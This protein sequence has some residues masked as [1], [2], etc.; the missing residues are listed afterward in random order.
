M[1]TLS[2]LGI[3]SGLDTAAMLEQMRAAEQTR[4]NPYTTLKSSYENKISAWGKISSALSSLQTSVKKLSGEAFNTL[5][6]SDNKAFKATATSEAAADSHSVTVK[7]LAVSHKLRTEGYTSSEENLGDKTGGTRTITITQANGKEITV[8]LADDETS[9]DQIAKAINKQDGGV[10]A[11]VQRSDD[12]YQLVL[13]SRTAGTEGQMSVQVT[14]DDALGDILNTSEGG[15]RP[16]PDDENKTIAENDRM[17]SVAEAQDAQLIVDGIS[18]TRSSNSITDI[19]AGVTLNLTGV[20]EEGKAEQLTLN[21]DTSAIK[22]TLQEFVKQYNALLS[23]TSSASKFVPSDTSGLADDDVAKPSSENGALM[24]D[25]TLRGLVG[26]LRSVVNGV[27]GDKDVNVSALSSLGISIDAATGQMTLDTEKLDKAIADYPEQIGAL[28][29]GNG[30]KEGLATGLNDIITKYVG[31]KENKKDGVIKGMTDTLD[32]QV[33]LVKEQI[34]KTQKLIDA[35][36][37]RYRIQFQNLDSTMSQL[38][39][40]S[41]QLTAVLSTL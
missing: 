19:I 14:G 6:V 29:K 15:Q 12:G 37:E 1:A 11:S 20:S 3:G 26:E 23:Q 7:Q 2:S 9:L 34:D 36:V 32:E 17:F 4:L 24:G 16:D 27:Y 35:Q 41:N 18:Y 33:K 38:N 25:G 39:N 40:M 30:E 21:V 5:T 31:D 13:S 22:T 8:S 10:R 28:F